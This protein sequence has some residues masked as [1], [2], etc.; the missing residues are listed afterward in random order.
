MQQEKKIAHFFPLKYS[1]DQVS[2]LCGF[3][4]QSYLELIA[5]F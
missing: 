4:I 5:T 2:Y 3:F 1:T